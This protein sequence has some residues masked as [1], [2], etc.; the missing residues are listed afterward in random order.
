MACS[1]RGPPERRGEWRAYVAARE[2]DLPAEALPTHLRWLLVA[3]LH[4]AG[5]SDVEIAEVTRLSTY[6]AGRIRARMGLKPNHK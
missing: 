4:R 6:T 1:G 2:G 3:E 5:L